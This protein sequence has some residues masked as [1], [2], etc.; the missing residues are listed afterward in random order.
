MLETHRSAAERVSEWDPSE[1]FHI[2]GQEVTVKRDILAALRGRE[3]DYVP[4]NIH[5]LLLGRGTFERMIRNAG[6]GIVEKSVSA[7][8]CVSPRVSFDQLEKWEKG[9]RAS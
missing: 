1:R 3:P 6:L 2:G 5:H 9:A 8:Q 7:Y 4:W